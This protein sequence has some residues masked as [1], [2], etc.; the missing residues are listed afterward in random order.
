MVWAAIGTSIDKS[1]LV[2]IDKDSD[3]LR[4]GYIALSYTDTLEEGLVPIYDGQTLQ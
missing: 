3:T 2:V 4:G 1:E